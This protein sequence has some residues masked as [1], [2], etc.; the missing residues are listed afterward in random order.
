MTKRTTQSKGDLLKAAT[1]SGQPERLIIP[2][3]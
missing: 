3:I 1:G 2:P